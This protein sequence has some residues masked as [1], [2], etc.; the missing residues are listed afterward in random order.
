MENKPSGQEECRCECGYRCGG[1]GKCKM[2][3]DECLGSN[4]NEHFVRDCGHNFKGPLVDQG[5]G[6]MSIECQSCGLSAM[7]HDC[8]KGP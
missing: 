1:P 3:M 6:A 8:A 4:N 7:D 2:S 5:N